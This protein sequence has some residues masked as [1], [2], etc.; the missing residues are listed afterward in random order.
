MDVFPEYKEDPSM[1]VEDLKIWVETNRLKLMEE[2]TETVYDMATYCRQL[3]T[4]C[5]D[6]MVRA[7]MG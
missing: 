4:V 1:I 6:D 5:C 3:E 7:I 2:K